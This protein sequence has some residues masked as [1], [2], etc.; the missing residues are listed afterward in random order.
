MSLELRG[1]VEFLVKE[2]EKEGVRGS[3]WSQQ[4]VESDVIDQIWNAYEKWNTKD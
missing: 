4:E 3:G 2:I 1:F